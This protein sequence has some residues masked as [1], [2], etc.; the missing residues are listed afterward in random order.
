MISFFL[1]WM[2]NGGVK[3]FIVSCI[4]LIAF[5]VFLSLDQNLMKPQKLSQVSKI[6]TKWT[7][8][9]YLCHRFIN[10]KWHVKTGVHF[11]YKNQKYRRLEIEKKT[12]SYFISEIPSFSYMHFSRKCSMFRRSILLT[13]TSFCCVSWNHIHWDLPV[14]NGHH[15]GWKKIKSKISFLFCRIN[16]TVLF[17]ISL[18]TLSWLRPLSYRNQ[19]IDFDCKSMIVFYVMGIFIIK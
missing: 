14:D 4:F 19:S 1:W 13:G 3:D 5:S 7:H 12:F 18:I 17:Q 15:R 6:L 11:F 2:E 10:Q 8:V 16:I 9:H